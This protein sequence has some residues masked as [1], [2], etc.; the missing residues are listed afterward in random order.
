VGP[1]RQTFIAFLLTAACAAPSWAQS[2]DRTT[3]DSIVG[4]EV[5]EERTTASV[6]EDKV[7]AAIDRTAGNVALVRKT[8]TV[9]QVDIVF[10]S[11]AARGEGGPPPRIAEK[12]RQHEGEI[13]ELRR[14]IE[15]NALLFHA[16][17]SR[18]VL[19]G[20]ILAVDFP[21]ARTVIV[22]AAAKPGG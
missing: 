22:Y 5:K 17:D 20:N 9:G 11:D 12:V 4:S 18:R 21:D 13:A 10:L 3:V 16:V 14:E 6:S 1:A 15:A 19:T 8:A 7:L 2:L